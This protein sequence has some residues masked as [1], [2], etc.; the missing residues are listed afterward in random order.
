MNFTNYEF[1]KRWEGERL[2]AYRDIGG[3]WTIGVGHTKNVKPG[4]TITSEESKE[5]LD[6]DIKWAVDTVNNSVKVHLNQNQFNALVSLCFNIGPTAFT[7]STC[8]RRLNNNDYP[9]A[10]E[11]LT[12]WNKDRINGK[13]VV[14]PGLVNRRNAEKTLFNAPT[15]YTNWDDEEVEK[16]TREFVL[17][18]NKIWNKG[19]INGK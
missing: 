2:E 4:Q 10:A 13:L 11:A 15:L 3:V 19:L 9:G 1:L 18:L 6:Q 17:N 16:L 8:L 14:V 12:W 5:F 7:G